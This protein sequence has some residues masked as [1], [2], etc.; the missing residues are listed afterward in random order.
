MSAWSVKRGARRKPPQP[1]RSQLRFPLFRHTLR[2]RCPVCGP[3]PGIQFQDITTL[4]LD[5]AAYAGVVESF[6]ER[7]RG[8]PLDAVACF[9]ARGFFFGPAVALALKLPLVPLRK[10][11]KLPGP[12][13][14][15]SYA[16]EYGTDSLEVHVGALQPGQR[17]LL[18]DDLMAT[19]GTLCAGIRLVRKA[20]AVPVGA[21]FVMSLPDIGGAKKVAEL[22]VRSFPCAFVASADA[23]TPCAARLDS[24]HYLGNAR[25]LRL[26][27]L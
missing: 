27:V 26:L 2:S 24:V 4:L 12:V 9:E 1:P 3:T 25:R 7:F 13:L 18:V 6:L 5:P 19:G 22:E 16:L 20:G 14:A 8:V 10:P 15:E 17:V 23:C 21:A 11:R